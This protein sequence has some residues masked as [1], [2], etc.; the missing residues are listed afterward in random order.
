MSI[1]TSP[2]LW[3]FLAGISIFLYGLELIE[4]VC[5][6]GSSTIQKIIQKGT[7]KKWKSILSGVW[8]ISILQSSHAV[9]L[10]ILAFVGWWLVSLVHGVSMVIGMNVGTV[11]TEALIWFFGLWF[12]IW[13]A[14]LPLVAIWWLG[15]LFNK[16]YKNLFAI[17]L[18]LGLLFFWLDM[19]K[20]SVAVLK[21]SIDITKYIQYPLIIYFF[22]W[23]IGTVLTQS[24]SAMTVIIMTAVFE[25]LIPLDVAAMTVMGCYVG[26]TTTALFVSL[27][28]GGLKKQVALSHFWFNVIVS[29]IF[30]IFFSWVIY[31][32]QDVR[33]FGT[34]ADWIWW[35]KKTSVNGFIVF[36]LLFK[37]VG[38]LLFMPFIDL[39]TKLIQK[40]A[41]S[42]D[43]DSLN[44]ES[45][46][47]EVSAAV[48]RDL[49]Q[50]D[51]SYFQ[52][53][54]TTFNIN[55]IND[56]DKFDIEDYKQLKNRF[57]KL[58]SFASNFDYNSIEQDPSFGE[59]NILNP[60]VELMQSSKSIKD[61][62]HEILSLYKNKN[63]QDHYN[64]IKDKY[65]K[66]AEMI[67][68]KDL[69]LDNLDEIV[70]DINDYESKL[71]SAE[72]KD[73]AKLHPELA[74]I[75]HMFNNIELSLHSM[76]TATKSI[77]SL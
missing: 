18:G 9:S 15:F 75:M 55:T 37:A 51:R 57:N 52:S 38:A 5:S 56:P 19:M 28:D 41:P 67:D 54:I 10:L 25:W 11:F 42:K 60:L 21:S 64:F 27:K 4:D 14:V 63:L 6:G 12:D 43:E 20:D 29:I 65:T 32:I 35:L 62:Q 34:G 73:S 77:R 3:M 30:G 16:R 26:T 24:S 44:I 31:L 48:Q 50:K 70:D 36:F 23:L 53:S 76:I 74:H 47:K 49:F 33:W 22:V 40:I 59:K 68:D 13:P 7:N 45:I 46:N 61:V 8:L 72:M 17:V 66:L 58:F 39:Y 1:L 2:N 69:K 71:I